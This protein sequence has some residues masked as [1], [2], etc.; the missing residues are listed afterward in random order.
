LDDR[1][2]VEVEVSQHGGRSESSGSRE[3]F[4]AEGEKLALS[5]T[6]MK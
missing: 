5:A 4:V 1:R 2:K 3:A 6:T